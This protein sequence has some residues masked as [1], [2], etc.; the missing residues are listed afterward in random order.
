VLE[1]ELFIKPRSH[2]PGVFFLVTF[3]FFAGTVFDTATILNQRHLPAVDLTG[4]EAIPVAR[5][6]VAAIMVFKCIV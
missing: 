1:Q 2:L 5:R 3:A 4:M 6:R